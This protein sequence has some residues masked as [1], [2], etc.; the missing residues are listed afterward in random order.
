MKKF[1]I[2][3]LL[4]II[5]SGCIF[6]GKKKVT[7]NN[8]S[9]QQN[10]FQQ[11]LGQQSRIK[12]FNS[13]EEFKKFL[14]DNPPSNSYYDGRNMMRG[15]VQMLAKDTAASPESS[16]GEVP[17]STDFST[18]NIQVAGVDEPDIIKS[19]GKYLYALV[20]NI[21]YIID[22]VP[23]E[24]TKIISR[25]KFSSRP[26][27]LF[28]NGNRLVVFG[29]DEQMPQSDLYKTFIRRSG[30]TFFKVFDLTDRAN[31]QQIKDLS[32]EG[33]YRDARMIGDYVYFLTQNYNYVAVDNNQILPRVIDGQ[34]EISQNCQGQNSKCLQPEIF[35]FDYPYSN[36]NLSTVLAVNV[37][38]VDEPMNE[39]IYL[40][41]DTQNI[42]VSNKNIYLSYTKYLNEYQIEMAVT[43]ELLWPNLGSED[44]DK[45]T[46]IEAVDNYILSN[47]EKQSKI[48][49]II[50]R[51][52]ASLPVS[53][54]E[55]WQKNI[56]QRIK[57]KY[58]DLSK[59]LE[60]TVIH[61]IGIDGGK[62]NYLTEGEIPGTVLNQFS[63]DEKDNYLR[64]AT[65]KNRSWSRFVT[66]SDQE[67]Y[68]NIYVLDSDLKLV[69]SVEKLA[70]GERIYAARFISDRVYLVTFQQTDPLFV[71]DLKEPRQPVVLGQLK[72]PGFSNY[73]HPYDDD[74][75]IGI[76]KDTEALPN[77]GVRT[78]GLKFS[79]FDVSNVK[80]PREIDTY[81]IG[82]LGSDSIALYDHKAFLF[83]ANKNM[84][85]IPVSITKA[86]Q[87]DS[88]GK[89]SFSGAL[90]LKVT[91]SGFELKGQVDHSDGGRVSGVD[92]FNGYEYYDNTVK[93]S[94]YIDDNLYTFSNQYLKINKISDLQS[95]KLLGWSGERKNDVE[96]LK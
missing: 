53:E 5:L 60:K 82:D 14:A 55:Q 64:V 71:I 78:K 39:N 49:A 33:N 89:L 29:A 20:Y 19:D 48:A 34:K 77:G 69:G 32:V 93:R 68:A 31:P 38:N 37:K 52:L 9:P 3:I 70:P 25:I 94:L 11:Q 74:T 10:G 66:E 41:S 63:F 35:Y 8:N 72:I 76:G 46:K 54:Q 85:V 12:K 23:A 84:L 26:Q 43:K 90:V 83:A 18:T 45:I 36:Y 61:K 92:P 80:A 27:D 73:L 96:I 30:Y 21:L 56:S 1:L 62:L 58:N 75:L 17:A 50:Q 87:P 42:Y 65:T 95:V 22:A 24:Q 6:G 47:E 2:I 44:K 91:K 86:M 57:E 88:Y 16:V 67:S 59:E 81:L 7:T 4:P 13:P 28:I 15:E 79:L 40:M 51:Y